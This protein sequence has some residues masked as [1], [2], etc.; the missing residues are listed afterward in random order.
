MQAYLD[1]TDAPPV[2]PIF[3]MR[4]FMGAMEHATAAV[5]RRVRE[6]GDVGTYWLDTS[7]W[8]DAPSSSH[9]PLDEGIE[10]AAAGSDASLTPPPTA[11]AIS[12]G[13]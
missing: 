3:V 5:V 8:L 10:G 6:E 12:G 4:P 1:T 13:T 11:T 7:G 2:I 9:S